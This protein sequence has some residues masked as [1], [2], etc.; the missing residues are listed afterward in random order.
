M[1]E[2]TA[3]KHEEYLYKL[4]K[5]KLGVEAAKELQNKIIQD[6]LDFLSNSEHR[7]TATIRL[8]ENGINSEAEI[9]GILANLHNALSTI[10]KIQKIL[11]FLV[12]FNKTSIDGAKI[13][14]DLRE[15]MYNKMKDKTVLCLH[16]Y[17]FYPSLY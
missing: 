2:E 14:Y 13:A 17:P 1:T 16:P 3:L 11:D 6:I 9:E 4:L 10:Q 8:V 15:G 7:L 12:N 5:N